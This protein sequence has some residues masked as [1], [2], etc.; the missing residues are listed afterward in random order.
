MLLLA[1]ISLDFKLVCGFHECLSEEG[2][3]ATQKEEQ[4]FCTSPRDTN[5]VGFK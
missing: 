4:R 5:F 3:A 2:S 1:I